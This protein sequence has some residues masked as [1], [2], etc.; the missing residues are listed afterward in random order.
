M[1]KMEVNLNLSL[2][3]YQ[4]IDGILALQML[5]AAKQNYGSCLRKLKVNNL[6]SWG[7]SLHLDRASKNLEAWRN[8]WLFDKMEPKFEILK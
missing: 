1:K 7:R 6:L 4:G 3:V 2:L 5:K 8:L